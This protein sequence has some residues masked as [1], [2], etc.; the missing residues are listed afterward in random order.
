MHFPPI[1]PKNLVQVLVYLVLLVKRGKKQRH[2][3]TVFTVLMSLYM[4]ITLKKAK[5]GATRNIILIYN[6]VQKTFRSNI[7]SLLQIGS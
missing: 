3:F 2:S 7:H 6:K 1:Q 5:K 4:V